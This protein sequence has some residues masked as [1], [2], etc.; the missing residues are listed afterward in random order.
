MSPARQ[1]DFAVFPAKTGPLRAACSSNCTRAARID[2]KA[3]WNYPLDASPENSLISRR[4]HDDTHS[5]SG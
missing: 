3:K 5:A 2:A 1:V 4:M